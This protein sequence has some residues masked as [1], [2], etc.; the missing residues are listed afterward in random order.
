MKLLDS[1]RHLS[2]SRRSRQALVVVTFKEGGGERPIHITYEGTSKCREWTVFTTRRRPNQSGEQYYGF[3]GMAKHVTTGIGK[4]A[5]YT[6]AGSICNQRTVQ[7]ILFVEVDFS[8][9][10][11]FCYD[12]M[13]LCW[14]REKDLEWDVTTPTSAIRLPPAPH[15]RPRALLSTR[16]APQ[17]PSCSV[18]RLPSCLGLLK[19]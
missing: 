17:K 15:R 4:S 19:A 6:A 5:I 18:P 8:R 11:S 16:C 7:Q 14:N 2:E 3:D 1:S 13:L 12:F 9:F 10:R